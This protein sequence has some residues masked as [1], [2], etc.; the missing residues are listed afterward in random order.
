MKL[1][2]HPIMKNIYAT[3]DGRIFFEI[4]ASSSDSGY[5][6]VKIPN[7]NNGS[8]RHQT[9]RRHVLMAEIFHGPRPDGMVVRHLDGDPTNDDPNNLIWGTQKENAN[10]TIKHGRTTKGSKNK[11]AKINKQQAIEI[12]KRRMLGESGRS[13]SIEFNI[14][15]S[16]VCDIYKGR[17]WSE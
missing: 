13:L 17:T 11:H 5:H 3:S 8:K 6:T 2:Q 14:T 1:T 15:Q 10:D 7:S 16:A 12:K 4:K 9:I